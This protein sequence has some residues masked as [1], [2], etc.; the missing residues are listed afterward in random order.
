MPVHGR[1]SNFWCFCVKNTFMV[2]LAK[3]Y[4]NMFHTCEVKVAPNIPRQTTINV[5]HSHSTHKH[6]DAFWKHDGW[7]YDLFECMSV[8]QGQVFLVRINSKTV[9]SSLPLRGNVH[10][11]S[12][13]P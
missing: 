7:I 6:C 11:L 5:F 9:I 12:V 2:W 4:I 10:S 13:Q 1:R 3:D 8:T